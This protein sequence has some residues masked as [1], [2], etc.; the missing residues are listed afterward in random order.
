MKKLVRL[1]AANEAAAVN[2]ETI[3]SINANNNRKA[4]ELGKSKAET[5]HDNSEVLIAKIIQ[6]NADRLA[7]E[8]T[9]TRETY[10]Q[11]RNTMI[12]FMCIIV[13]VVMGVSYWIIT[14]IAKS[15]ILAKEAIKAVAEGDLT[16]KVDTTTK[17]EIGELLQYLQNMVY[18]LKSVISHVTTAS[19]TIG[20]ASLQMNSS[21]GQL[22]QGATEQAASAEEV[23]SSMEEMTSNIQQNTDN[24]QQTEKIALQAALD[25]QEGSLAVNQTVESMKTIAKKISIIEE[26]AKQ[27]NL[28]ALNAAVEAARAGE[29]GK[30][31]AVVAAE[32]RKLAEKS[33]LAA[34]EIN[35]L[36]STSVEIAEKSGKLLEA[37]VPNIEKTSRLVQEIAASSM[38]QFSGAEQINSAVQQLNQV[39]QNNAA[40][41]EETAA[42]SEELSTQAAQLKTTIAFF[43]IDL[44]TL[45]T[46][47]TNA[48]VKQPST[49][50]PVQPVNNSKQTISGVKLDMNSDVLDHEFEKY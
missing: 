23:S 4:H 34:T 6:M 36:S 13:I 3:K 20:S 33:Q 1:N 18:K 25:I 8:K 10:S 29:H 2:D 21:S 9:E 45:L 48:P 49:S 42:S 28:L 38:E 22:S 41:A 14:S 37:I 11:S 47:S 19:E 7:V 39:I 26:I 44:Q 50:A 17:D 27:T 32:V 40:S 30:G 24:A 15:L 43:K 46:R 35:I 31:F 12:F 16:I 5:F